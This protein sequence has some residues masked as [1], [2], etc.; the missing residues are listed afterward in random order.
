[1]FQNGFKRIT[2]FEDCVWT[3]YFGDHLL[4]DLFNRDCSLNEQHHKGVRFKHCSVQSQNGN[5]KLICPLGFVVSC[6]W[7]L[8]PG[9]HARH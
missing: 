1:M 9:V 6:F 4:V 8:D 5:C 3:S 7:T 2:P